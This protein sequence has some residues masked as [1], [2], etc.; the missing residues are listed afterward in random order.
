MDRK[1]QINT[2]SSFFR[3][4]RE[5]IRSLE[6]YEYLVINA[7]KKLNLIGNSTINNI[8]NRHIT[9][10]FQV[11]DFV[12]KNHK[13]LVDIGTGAGLPGIV[14]AIAAN[15]R[16]IP[17]KVVL[18]EKSPKKVKFLENTINKL[19][20]NIKIICQNIFKEK[21]IIGDVFVARAFKPLPVILKLIH[22]K[23]LNYKNFIIFLG[24]T[25]S[26]ELLQASKSW[27]IEYKQR[28]SVTSSDSTILEIKK[29]E[30]K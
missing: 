21:K 10:S 17:L 18:V 25:G 28:V 2:F 23:A 27:N 24:K 13:I 8:W 6:K 16:K 5:T 22:N 30:K 26:T 12:D 20:L 7:N 15:E 19:D 29:L 9:D 14:L 1:N 3:V 11:I 4:S